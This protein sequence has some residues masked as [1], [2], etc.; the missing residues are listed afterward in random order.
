MKITFIQFLNDVP[1]LGTYW[2]ADKHAKEWQVDEKGSWITLTH[3]SNG[4]RRRVPI[5]SVSAISEIV[6]EAPAKGRGV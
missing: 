5:T 3:T 6:V 4:Q 1:G 2:S